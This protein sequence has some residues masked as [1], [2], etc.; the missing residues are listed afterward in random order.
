MANEILGYTPTLNLLLYKQGAKNWGVGM[1]G[2]LTV[3]DNLAGT[4]NNNKQ[5][6]T[7]LQADVAGILLEALPTG[8]I[9]PYA[10]STPPVG[11]LECNGASLL[12]A[13]YPELFTVIGTTFGADDANHFSLPDYRDRY[14]RGRSG[15]LAL[16]DTLEDAFQGHTYQAGI[17]S[18]YFRI[19]PYQPAYAI[20]SSYGFGS[21]GVPV[22]DGT[23]GTPRTASETRPKTL[24]AAFIIKY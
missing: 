20:G 22:T 7:E 11:Y 10:G 18:V 2:N 21:F 23:N 24:V 12:R 1:N 6:I 15:G 8:I 4:V 3:L 13:S 16:G 17:E 5:D 9:L 14:P 19:S